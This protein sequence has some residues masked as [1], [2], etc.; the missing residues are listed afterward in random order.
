MLERKS[1]IEK[2]KENER[3]MKEGETGGEEKVY[4]EMKAQVDEK[5]ESF[6]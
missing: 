2:E 3:Q 1:N 6:P 5:R 4:K